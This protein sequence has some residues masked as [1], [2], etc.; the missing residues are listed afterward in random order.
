M[1]T[2]TAKINFLPAISEATLHLISAFEGNNISSDIESVFESKKSAKS[3]F[4]IG[5]SKLGDSSTFSEKVDYF[6]GKTFSDKNGNFANSYEFMLRG[7]LSSISH[8]T[9]AFDT[10]NNRHP[11]SI[12][13]NGVEYADD[14]AIFTIPLP[15][16]INQTVTI[17]NWNTPNSPLVISGIY[18][19]VTIN[20]DKHNMVILN[21]SLFDRPNTK[22]PEYGI[23]S[24]S[25]SVDFKDLNGE[26]QDYLI[27]SS[28]IK[29]LDIEIT[30]KNTLNKKSEK[31]GLFKT[32]NWNYDSDN[33]SVSVSLKDD[34]EEWQDISVGGLDYDPRNSYQYIADGK[35][36]SLYKW[37]Q[38]PAITPTKYQML[39][40]NELDNQTQ[41]ILENTVLQYPMLKNGS[42]WE[43]W[44]KLCEVCGLYI[45]KNNQGKTTCSYNLGS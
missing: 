6:I 3:P 16:S 21:R 41:S 28:K 43:Q 14:D 25:G 40:F 13:I 35:M 9:I 12:I 32:R 4:I 5:A 1:I 2:L 10:V 45:Y 38:Q 42:L 7:G 29:N 20:I 24:N 33:R 44:R 36:S 19:E 8:I 37:L 11:K 39:P 30:L 18:T 27:N 15:Y 31:V 34:L 22:L 23:I 26:I 17:S